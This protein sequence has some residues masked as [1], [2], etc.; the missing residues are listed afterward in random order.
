MPDYVSPTNVRIHFNGEHSIFAV[1]FADSQGTILSVMF[2]KWGD[3]TEQFAEMQVECGGFILGFKDGEAQ[4]GKC[5]LLREP[6]NFYVLI[7]YHLSDVEEPIS[8]I[9]LD[10][11]N[12]WLGING[13]EELDPTRVAIPLRD[14]TVL[15]G[16]NGFPVWEVPVRE[17][18]VM[19]VAS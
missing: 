13:S 12:L 2:E 6:Y 14:K 17:G 1:D 4:F 19:L 7:K 10:G 5:F 15:M 18:I 9:A 11:E 3:A 16:T 8:T